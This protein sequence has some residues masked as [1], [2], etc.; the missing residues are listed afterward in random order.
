MEQRRGRRPSQVRPR[1]PN[2]ERS[3]PVRARPPIPTADRLSPHKRIQRGPG[4]P[5]VARGAFAAGVVVLIGAVIW[6]ASGGIG[7]VFNGLSTALGGVVQ[8]VAV[9]PSPTVA[10]AE[11]AS[12]APMI[13]APDQPYVRTDTVDVTVQVPHSVAGHQDRTVRLWLTRP[14]KDPQMVGQAEV[15]VTPTV[16]LPDIPLIKG[17]N[18]FQATILGPSAESEPSSVVAWILDLVRP[19]ITIRVPRTNNAVVNRRTIGIA[20]K[21]QG[22]SSVT[23]RN[24]ATGATATTQSADDGSFT[25]QVALAEGTN[26][27]TITITDPA[28]N[29]NTRV[30]TVRRGTGKLVA[31]LRASSYRF[32]VSNLPDPVEFSVTVTDP[33]GRPLADATVLFTITVPGLEPI[34]SSE[35]TTAGDGTASFRTQISRGATPGGGLASVLVTTTDFGTVADRQVLTIVR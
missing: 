3:R 21:T 14:D 2:S 29:V 8:R 27:I 7:P 1:P 13:V 12:D 28:G 25:I 33:D 18:A 35:L 16:V 19:P 4:L 26:G 10:A 5:L 20:G 17:R 30:V 22:R 11:P 24:E 34:V 23:A 32:K 9:T 6:V 31:S 15:G